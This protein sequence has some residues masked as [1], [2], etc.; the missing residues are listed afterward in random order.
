VNLPVLGLLTVS[1]L[2]GTTFVAV[3]SGLSDS[4]PL[5]FV[6]VRFLVASLAALPLLRG[7]AAL[8]DSLRAGIP[9]GVVLACGYA[10]QTIG[11][12]TTTPAR[13]AF[14]TA[15]NVVFVPILAIPV[16]RRRARGLSIA[17]LALTLPGVWLLTSPG[18][19]RWNAGD[20]WTLA[21]ALFFALHVVLVNRWGRRHD[22]SGLLVSQLL[23]TAAIC[24]VAA[25]LVEP[26]R[27]VP[28]GRLAIALLVTAVFATTGVT[29]LQL[30]FQPRVD[31]TR[32]ALVYATEPVFATFFS[33]LFTGEVLPAV[34]WLGGGLILA[35]MVLSEVGS[36]GEA[37]P[38]GSPIPPREE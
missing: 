32:A 14:V 37:D 21:C 35:G 38:A 27:L 12:T 5:L 6:G 26:V 10:T 36:G 2:W 20:A 15:M 23:V 11:L 30:R 17:G 22:E 24:L 8:V 34:G 1:L 9:L 3:K 13:S 18:G 33:W 4:S 25:P 28:T 16:L 31:P 29:W 19:G 7:R